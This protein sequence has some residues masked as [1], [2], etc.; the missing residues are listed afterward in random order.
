M[1]KIEQKTIKNDKKTKPAYNY[2]WWRNNNFN[3]WI[4]FNYYNV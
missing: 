3:N 4:N 2:P 1:V